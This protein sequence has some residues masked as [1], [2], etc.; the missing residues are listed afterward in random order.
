MSRSSTT[1][2]AGRSLRR[3]L[4][5]GDRGYTETGVAILGASLVLGAAL[6]SGAASSVVTMSDGVTWLTDDQTGQLVQVNPGTGRAERR[7]TVAGAGADLE[8]SQQDGHLVVGDGRTGT[9]TSIDLATLLT[10]GQRRSDERMRVLVGGGQAYLVTPSTGVVRAVDALTLRDLGAPYRVGAELVDVVVDRS[11]TVWA[12]TSAGR[13]LSLTWRPR[14][15]AFETGESTV[16]GGGPGTRLLPHD[17]GVTVFAPDGGAVLQVGAGRDLSVAVPHLDGTVLPADG[18]PTN[19]APAGLPDSSTVVLLAGDRIR[20]IRVG[21]LGCE[22]PGRPA[23]FAGLV[24]VPC[25]G[26]GRVIVLRPDGARARPDIVV[27]GGRDPRLLVDDGHLVVQTEDG[28]RAVMVETDGTTRVIDTG[29]G[30][31]AVHD[32]N[33]PSTGPAAARAPGRDQHPGGSG[34]GEPG[35]DGGAPDEAPQAPGSDA[36]EPSLPDVPLPLPHLPGGTSGEPLAPTTGDRAETEAP[37]VSASPRPAASPSGGQSRSSSA[38]PSPSPSAPAVGRPSAV[39]VRLGPLQSNGITDATVTWRAGSPRPDRHV[40]RASAGGAAPVTVAGDAT[41]ATLAGLTCATSLLVTVEAVTDDGRSAS[42]ESAVV[43]TDECPERAPNAPTGVSATAHADGSVTVSWT[44]TRGDVDSYLVGPL[45]GSTTTAAGT[46]TSIVLRSLPPGDGVRFVVQAVRGGQSSSSL[47]SAPITVPG[48][49]GATDLGPSNFLASYYQIA[50]GRDDVQVTLAWTV[51]DDGG[52]PLTGYLVTWSAAGGVSGSVSTT[53]TSYVIRERCTGEPLCTSGGPFTMNVTP[54]NALGD[55]PTTS[56]TVDIR[57]APPVWWPQDGDEVVEHIDVKVPGQY[58]PAFEMS[59]RLAPPQ[60]WVDHTGGCT[61]EVTRSDGPQTSEPI[62]CAA[63]EYSLGFFTS[64]GSVTVTVYAE[65]VDGV[66]VASAPA[67]AP[68]PSRRTWPLCDPD[69]DVCQASAVGADVVVVPIPWTPRLPQ[70][71]ERP[72]LVAGGAG[73]VLV[74]GALRFARL[75]A[76]RADG[77]WS[78]SRTRSRS[79]ARL[80]EKSSE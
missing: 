69:T 13:L 1:P 43:K 80:A 32:P 65:D 10:G 61:I 54:R 28:G 15:R 14:D 53:G 41:T 74:A 67:T 25:E 76:A 27:P 64:V 66:R 16:R 12:V 71:D 7:L 77:S 42:A 18:S 68:V 50:G 2:Q 51:P 46:A 62:G 47:P 36:P 79:R 22:R 58:E 35:R 23:V 48:P 40:V 33:D 24:Y 44:A 6:G 55:G 75:R 72:P 4:T 5:G 29:R 26:A 45:G 21:A 31:V 9:V 30:Q 59:A 49:P 3:W 38:S 8:V 19:L 63:T 39:T 60:S 52:S 17:H 57:P 34:D 37:D 11:G 56:A 20:E 73:L 70:G 78:R